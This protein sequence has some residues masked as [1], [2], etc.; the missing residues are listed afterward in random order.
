MVSKGVLVV[1]SGVGMLCDMG[2]VG[3]V[4]GVF[5]VEGVLVRFAYDVGVR[6]FW[7]VGFFMNACHEGC[8]SVVFGVGSLGSLRCSVPAG[9]SRVDRRVSLTVRS[10]IFGLVLLPWGSLA[11]MA[12]V[13]CMWYVKAAGDVCLMLSRLFHL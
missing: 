12:S 2:A 7:K 3:C 5:V 6:V 10:C 11:R 1:C 13:S 8:M 9:G 4:R